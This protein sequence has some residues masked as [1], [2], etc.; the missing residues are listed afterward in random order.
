MEQKRYVIKS[1]VIVFVVALLTAN[2]VVMPGSS[3]MMSYVRDTEQVERTSEFD[4]L[5]I[6]IFFPDVII[7]NHPTDFV[8]QIDGLEEPEGFT[9]YLLFDWGS[10]GN[11][12]WIGPLELMA[13]GRT[14]GVHSWDLAVGNYE[15]KA[16]IKDEYG[17][18]Y[19]WTDPMCIQIVSHWY[20]A[21]KWVLICRPFMDL[22]IYGMPPNNFHLLIY[23]EY[24]LCGFGRHSV[25]WEVKYDLYTDNM[26][27]HHVGAYNGSDVLR[28]LKPFA[29]GCY[30]WSFE[31]FDRG[32]V[33][34]MLYIDDIFIWQI[35]YY[36]ISE[37]DGG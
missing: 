18:E 7:K 27:D 15:I 30:N 22:T 10:S 3:W 12:E 13:T 31:N 21:I 34:G 26:T 20:Q 5:S 28:W 8:I 25:Q 33:W 2:I 1:G 36:I 6:T 24:R 23:Y 32:E 17:H 9:F 37:W 4:S 16:K 29:K 19:G 11:G 14:K 35:Y